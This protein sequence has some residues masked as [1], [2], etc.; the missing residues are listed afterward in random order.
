MKHVTIK[1]IARHLSISASTVSRALVNDKNVRKETKE[2]VLNA[3]RELNYK[4]NPVATNLKYGHSNT[5]GV[6]VPEMVTPF[7]STVVSGIQSVLYAHGIKVIVADSRENPDMERENIL[8]GIYGPKA[9]A[10]LV[11]HPEAPVS[12]ERAMYQCG[13][14]GK[15]ESRLAVMVKAPVRVPIL[16]RCDCG[17]TMHRIRSGKDMVCPACREPLK[18]TDI[19]AVSLWD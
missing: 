17:A 9:Q 1:D 18:K 4:P 12:V 13:A 6:I 16:Q 14:C 8:A 10:A 19:V 2:K 7:A 5:V 11:A 3:A 15:L